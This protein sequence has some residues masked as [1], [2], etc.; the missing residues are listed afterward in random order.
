[1][2][3][4]SKSKKKSA[5][6]AEQEKRRKYPRVETHIEV[7]YWKYVKFKHKDDVNIGFVKNISLGGC[8]IETD[9]IYGVNDELAFEFYLPNSG[10]PL[11][12]RAEVIWY[13]TPDDITDPSR[14]PGMGLKFG[15]FDDESKEILETFITHELKTEK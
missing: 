8:F 2:P 5:K 15:H 3:K 14:M 11:S 9:V 1:M 6:K 13:R 10:K 7:P 4:G 12:G